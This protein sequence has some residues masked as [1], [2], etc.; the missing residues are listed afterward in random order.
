[1]LPLVACLLILQAQ[2]AE[3]DWNPRPAPEPPAPT[4]PAKAEPT[5]EEAL[6]ASYAAE[7]KAPKGGLGFKTAPLQTEE[8]RIAAAN[9]AALARAEQAGKDAAAVTP[10]PDEGKTRCKPTE[11]GFVCGTSEKALEPDSPSRQALDSL[12]NKPN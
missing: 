8:D 3:I 11:T 6:A 10:W 12:L 5:F 7:D 1:M 4:A 9:A 2:P